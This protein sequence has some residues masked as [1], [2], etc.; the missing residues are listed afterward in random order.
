MRVR[1]SRVL[2]LITVAMCVSVP[3]WIDAQD[4]RAA[5]RARMVEDQLVHPH[6][7]RRTQPS[8]PPPSLS[9][10][11]AP[12]ITGTDSHVEDHLRIQN[13]KVLEAM[14]SVPRHWFVP[15]SVQA[16][17]YTDRPLPIGYGQTISQPYIVAMMT[18]LLNPQPNWKVL[19]VGTGSGYQA[20]ILTKFTPNV[21]TIEIVEPLQKQA[22][23]RLR[24]FGLDEKHVID[25]DGYAGL[26]KV[27]PFDGII[28]TASASQIP[29]P[30][31]EQLKPGGRM[32]VPVGSVSAKQRLLVVEKDA[33]GKVRTRTVLPVQFVPLTGEGG[34]REKK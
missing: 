21:Y 8:A 10:D 5:E 28:V 13:P 15:Q 12:R 31:L 14:R 4:D 32:V 25:G 34:T 30:L 23:A 24:K 22:L 16:D 17:A 19:E 18:E 20:A 29:A 3:R 1:G 11:S 33:S 9:G 27:A 2:L 7:G 6:F 26:P